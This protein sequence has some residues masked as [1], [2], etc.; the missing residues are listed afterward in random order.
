MNRERTKQ[1]G[2]GSSWLR[3]SAVLGLSLLLIPLAAAAPG[4]RQ[5]K[6]FRIPTDE[7]FGRLEYPLVVFAVLAPRSSPTLAASAFADGVRLADSGTMNADLVAATAAFEKA[8]GA[9]GT[10]EEPA[11]YELARVRRRLDDVHGAANRFAQLLDLPSSLL[12]A[13]ALRELAGVLSYDCAGGS[14]A[15]VRHFLAGRAA[16]AWRGELWR[17]IGDLQF[18]L[19]RFEIADE[20]YRENLAIEPLGRSAPV[21]QAAIV[22]SLRHQGAIEQAN[23]EAQRLAQYGPGTPWYEANQHDAAALRL[24]GTVIEGRTADPAEP[25]GSCDSVS[26]Q[27]VLNGLRPRF[28]ACLADVSTHRSSCTGRV[29]LAV[30]WRLDGTMGVTAA[31]N[32]S[33]GGPLSKCVVD[34]LGATRAPRPDS[35]CRTTAALILE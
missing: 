35:E 7:C 4:K 12:R 15:N 34:A 26:L 13:E 30:Q 31:E 29:E 33:C 5:V 18:E 2:R 27:R 17:A 6:I 19:S 10:L 22:R 32:G 3:A 28:V 16:P 1:C 11:L 24:A 21:V 25:G 14:V 9:P 23:V 20:A 8:V